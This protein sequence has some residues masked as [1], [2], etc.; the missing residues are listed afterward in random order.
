LKL[1]NNLRRPISASAVDDNDLNIVVCLIHH[2]L[3]RTLE[4]IGAIHR[5]NNRGDGRIPAHLFFVPQR[6]EPPFDVLRCTT[7]GSIHRTDSV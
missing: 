1:R 7:L 2:T 5:W 6:L 3:H 4:V